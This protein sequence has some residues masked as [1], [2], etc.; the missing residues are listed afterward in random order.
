MLGWQPISYKA[1]A[2][3]LGLIISVLTTN[4]EAG[5]FDWLKRT[6]IKWSPEIRGVVTEHGKPVAGIPIKRELYYDG[7]EHFDN[8]TTDTNGHFY[9]PQK[10]LKVRRVLFDVSIALELFALDYPN[11]G[12][13]NIIFQLRTLNDLNYKSLDL[14][15][16]D[17]RCELQGDLKHYELRNLEIPGNHAPAFGAKCT[18]PLAGSALF[19]D[20]EIEAQYQE[21]EQLYDEQQRK[22][23]EQEKGD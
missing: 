13:E 17:M 3:G 12:E 9:F 11:P 20:E 10:N 7:K 22:L 6:E 5:V 8:A 18:F 21:L 23:R 15:A 16:A 19:S 2:V 1:M 14:V 4:V